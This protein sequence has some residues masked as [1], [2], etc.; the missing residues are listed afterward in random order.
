MKH[1][2]ILASLCLF[3]LSAL[4]DNVK[5]VQ[6][7]I[8]K[9]VIIES[10]TDSITGT[11]KTVKTESTKVIPTEAT[12]N[13]S[14]IYDG[15]SYNF[16]FSWKKKKHLNPHW[17]GIGMG[18]MNYDDVPY[19]DLKGSRSHN[20][21][22]NFMEFQQ[23]I[24]N[25]NWLLVSG[26]GTEWSRYHFDDN[27]ALTK[28]DGKT[29]FQPAAEGINYKSTKLLAYYLTVPL[30]LEYQVSNF[31]ISG[32][33]VGFFKFY[34]KSQVKYYEDG[35]KHVKNMGRDLNMRSVDLKLR[36]QIGFDDVALYGY[37]SPFS[38]FE[39][40]K[41]PDLKTYTIGIMIGL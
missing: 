13:S 25:S 35:K 10:V 16:I 17:T 15:S 2:L 7:T 37:Y 6:D 34:S 40:D 18:F 39:K 5:A 14:V 21:T 38:M 4:A 27:A 23:H 12:S 31:H 9:T 20:F 22:L 28:I 32:G 33:A 19:G 11:T 1:L 26:V 29:V 30:L 8:V 36:L 41:G 3:S 24:Q